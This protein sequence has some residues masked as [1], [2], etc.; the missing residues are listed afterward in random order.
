MV[1]WRLKRGA[2]ISLDGLDTIMEEL[3]LNNWVVELKLCQIHPKKVGYQNEAIRQEDLTSATTLETLNLRECET[4]KNIG[5]I[6]D[7]SA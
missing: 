6:R 4:L 3:H 2:I 1:I 7:L 5:H